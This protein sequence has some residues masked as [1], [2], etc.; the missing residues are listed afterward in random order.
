MGKLHED[1]DDAGLRT[2]LEKLSGALDARGGAAGGS[3]ETIGRDAQQSARAMSVGVRVLSEF[4][5]A[6]LIGAFLGWA[7]DGW[8]GVAPW[9]LVAFLILGLA[10][11][12]WNVYR[13]ATT[14]QVGG[15][16]G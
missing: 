9:G 1:G 12:L 14:N 15:G 16:P 2:R 11:G 7:L 6:I 4:V 8:L 5:G 3:R 13:I 10:A